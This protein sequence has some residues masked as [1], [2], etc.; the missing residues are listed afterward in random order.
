M[1]VVQQVGWEFHADPPELPG[2]EVVG[3]G[4]AFF[5]GEKAQPWTS[6]IFFPAEEGAAAERP[7]QSRCR[8][9]QPAACV[10]RNFVFN[11]A[12]IFW[13][14]GLGS[15]PGHVLPWSHWS[16]PHGPDARVQRITLNLLQRASRFRSHRL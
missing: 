8:G 16:R 12:T 7:R 6:T 2:L 13:A 9:T 5:Q 1:S 11:A 15:P 4:Q 14:Q 10:D 3:C